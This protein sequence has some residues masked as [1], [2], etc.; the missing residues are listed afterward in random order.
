MRDICEKYEVDFK[1]LQKLERYFRKIIV[2]YEKNLNFFRK[3][4]RKLKLLESPERKPAWN[5]EKK[6]KKNQKN[7]RKIK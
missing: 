6:W 7:L 4:K 2:K 5:L 1:T 3:F